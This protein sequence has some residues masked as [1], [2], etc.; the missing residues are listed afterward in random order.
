MLA[1]FDQIEVAF[2]EGGAPIVA[3]MD[4]YTRM[5]IGRKTC[6]FVM[7]CMRNPELNAKIQARAAELR[8]EAEQKI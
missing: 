5:E 4:E 6:C 3:A 2:P 1:L 8:A 7:R